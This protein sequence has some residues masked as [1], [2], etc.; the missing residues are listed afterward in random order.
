MMH[1]F[2]RGR[3]FTLI[4]L[5]VVIAIIALLIGILLPALGKARSTA[6]RAGCLSNL[7]QYGIGSASYAT[8]FQDKIP[9][10]TWTADSMNTSYPDLQNPPG[11][12]EATMYQATDII[13]RRTGRDT[14]PRLN[15]LY[16]HRRFTHL[17]MLDYIGNMLPS[18]MVVCP[19][20][21]VLLGWQA[22]PQD[23]TEIPEW[24]ELAVQA[25]WPYSSTYQAVPASWAEDSGSNRNTTVQQY[26]LDY[27]LMSV[28]SKPL[29]RRKMG[30][31]SFP[32][33][34]VFM[35]EFHDR[36][37]NRN[38]IFYAYEVAQSSQLMFDGSVN[39]NKTGDANPGFKPNQPSS[40]QPTIFIY[41]PTVLSF[42][43]EPLYDRQQGD[44][45][46]GYYR[47]TRGGLKGADYGSKE[48]DTG[49][50]D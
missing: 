28:G 14:F 15:E 27:N 47:W 7:K 37:T 2:G 41:K 35:F 3:G 20:D 39:S 50:M 12:I 40:R 49:Q 33:Q 4:E 8:D 9:S 22:N 13:R 45:V 29:G 16:P 11:D 44:R 5:L 26:G 1:V 21:R 38:G 43:P 17:V 31:V 46:T 25:M 24:R 36:H 30:Q 6:R 48:I 23:L 19:E 34:K 10:Y 32:G 42:E 18:E